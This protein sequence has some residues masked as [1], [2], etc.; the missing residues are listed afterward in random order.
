M[1]KTIILRH[2][3]DWADGLD[4][5]VKL[6]YDIERKYNVRSTAFIRHDRGVSDLK[7]KSFYEQ[8]E[9]EGWEFGLHLANHENQKGYIAPERELEIVKRLGLNIRGLSACGGN[10]RWLDPNGWIVQDNVGLKYLCPS[11]LKKPDGYV[12]KTTLAPNHRTL[13][14]HYM[15]TYGDACIPVLIKEFSEL[16]EREKALALLSHNTWFY[17]HTPA[18]TQPPQML[19]SGKYYEAFISYFVNRPED[20]QFKTYADYLNFE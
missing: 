12:M 13:D 7:H 3:F 11:S 4:E 14:G 15:Q 9:S 2:D 10:Y 8:M 20:Y 1:V 18:R 19:K 6:M 17:Q 16:I 5:G